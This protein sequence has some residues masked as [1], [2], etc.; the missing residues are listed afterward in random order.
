MDEK[1]VLTADDVAKRLFISKPTAYKVIKKLNEEL[2]ANGYFTQ[3]GRVPTKYFN[4][5]FHM[6]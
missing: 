6:V 5:K 3:Q 1:Q 2:K 4:D